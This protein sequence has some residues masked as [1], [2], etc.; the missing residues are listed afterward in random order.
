MTKKNV[1]I[2]VLLK[3]LISSNIVYRNRDTIYRFDS[4]CTGIALE[5]TGGCSSGI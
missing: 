5:Q 2:L 4:A 1:I 3:M